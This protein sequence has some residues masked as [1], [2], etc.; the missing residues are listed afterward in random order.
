MHKLSTHN[1]LTPRDLLPD[2]RFHGTKILAFPPTL[3][4]IDQES[5]FKRRDI[6]DSLVTP[7]TVDSAATGGPFFDEI[8]VDPALIQNPNSPGMLKYPRSR[9]QLKR[10]SYIPPWAIVDFVGNTEKA[11]WISRPPMEKEIMRFVTRYRAVYK[12]FVLEPSC[13]RTFGIEENTNLS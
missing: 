13:M 11:L 2:I 10:V 3:Y 6:P 7:F 4:Y 8:Y 1:H 9:H 5:R 12:L